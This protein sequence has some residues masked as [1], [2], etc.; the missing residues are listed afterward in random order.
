MEIGA[1]DGEV[2][3]RFRWGPGGAGHLVGQLASS[4]L[5]GKPQLR[6]PTGDDEQKYIAWAGRSRFLFS[7]LPFLQREQT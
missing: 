1:G 7:T 5:P 3:L 4:Y 2:R 6:T